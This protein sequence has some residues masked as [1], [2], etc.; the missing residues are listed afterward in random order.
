MTFSRAV[1]IQ[2]LAPPD[3][4][5]LRTLRLKALRD[6]PHALL[7]DLKREAARSP[8]EWQLLMKRQTWFAARSG[9]RA[10]GLVSS[11]RDPD[12][13]ERYVE[14][15]WVDAAFRGRGVVGALLEA[16]EHLAI[17]E[18]RS[19]LLLWVLEG[20]AAAA[21]AYRR[22]GF[23]ES[24]LRQSVPGRPELIETQFFLDVPSHRFLPAIPSLFV[25]Q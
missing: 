7:G 3:W 20:N 15:M 23:R 22:Y 10:V 11:L 16:V 13:D 24:G 5:V 9:G 14:S 8:A 21:D 25:G 4:S 12:S 2:R 17:R 6:A 18:G 1:A 19:V